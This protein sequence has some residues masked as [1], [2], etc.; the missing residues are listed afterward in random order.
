MTLLIKVGIFFLNIAFSFMKLLP[1]EK[2]I[3]YISRQSNSIPIDFQLLKRTMEIKLPEYKNVILVRRIAP[4]IMG[5]IRYFFHMLHQMYH[6]ATSE[7][8][9]LDTYCIAV[10]VL[11]Q[12]KSLLVVQIW[13]A[14]GALKKFG[15]SILD[16]GEGSSSR[17]ARAMKMHNNYSYVFASGEACRTYFAEAFHQPLSAVKVFPLP[18]LD[19]LLCNEYREEKRREIKK[20]YPFL[21]EDGKKI[22]VYAPTFRKSET[23]MC[24]EVQR[25]FNMLD[26]QK[27]NLIFKPHP[28]SEIFQ[29]NEKVICD[30]FFITEDM[31]FLA[32]YVITDYSAIIFEAMLQKKKIILYAFDYIKYT[33]KRDFYLDYLH[34]FEKSIAYTAEDVI[35]HLQQESYM[36]IDEQDCFFDQ[37]VAKPQI[38]YTDDICDFLIQERKIN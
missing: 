10:S 35:L 24:E 11:R 3:L 6:L 15:Y 27:Y 21:E 7:I 13:H 26:Y 4:G 32:D 36:D 17:I 16:K 19:I 29:K 18:R 22:I 34:L 23:R 9:I 38:T 37:I 25:L 2:K 20:K 1:V 5:K 28:L 12:R 14:L 30:S 31:L 33:E 8:V